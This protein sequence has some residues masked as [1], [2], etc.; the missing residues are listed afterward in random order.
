MNMQSMFL[1]QLEGTQAAHLGIF[2]PESR[3]A[4]PP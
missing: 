3:V 2:P 1:V 4:I